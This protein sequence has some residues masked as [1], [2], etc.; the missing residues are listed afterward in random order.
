MYRS[1]P[2]LPE[3]YEEQVAEEE[4]E[5]SSFDQ[6]LVEEEEEVKESNHLKRSWSDEDLGD[7]D[8]NTMDVQE[9]DECLSTQG[10]AAPI[11]ISLI[12]TAP[13][14]AK[15]QNPAFPFTLDLSL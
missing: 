7:S 5:I 6:D 8:D 2:P 9:G 3:E 14:T 1:M 4:E 10:T 12:R 13:P 11:M 15:R